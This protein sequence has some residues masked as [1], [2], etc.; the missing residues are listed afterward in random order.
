MIS[1]RFIATLRW[2]ITLQIRYGFYYVSGFIVMLFGALLSL[3]PAD[4][5]FDLIIPAFLSMNLLIT[6]FYFM[7]ALVLLEKGEGTLSSVVVSPLKDREYLLSKVIS[8]SGLA[9]LESL[10]IV[11]VVYGVDF[12]LIP[13]LFGM[14][15]LSGVYSLLGFIAIARYNTL[16]DYLMPS[17]LII[18]LLM[19]PMI[20]H[21]GLWQTMIFHLH[22]INPMVVLI[23]AGFINTNAWELIYGVVGSII[24]IGVSFAWARQIFRQ[25][26]VR[27]AGI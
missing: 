18:T 15:A 16:N 24:V 25:F 23:R 9:M 21:F 1:L 13:V 17:M 10:V 3:L 27:S 26:I 8:L 20:D 5:R 22:P 7:S 2:D 6:T 19:L 11:A 14:I 12:Q 4:S